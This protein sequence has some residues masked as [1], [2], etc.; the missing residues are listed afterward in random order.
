MAILQNGYNQNETVTIS[1][2]VNVLQRRYQRLMAAAMSLVMTA[3]P[4]TALAAGTK[5][6]GDLSDAVA[7]A[8]L[9]QESFLPEESLLT[10]DFENL[11]QSEDYEE[12]EEAFVPFT[13]PNAVELVFNGEEMELA[14]YARLVD[15]MTCVPVR[16]FFEA[17]E[18]EVNWD[19]AAGVIAI[20]R[21]DGL[22]MELIPGD[23]LARANGRCWYMARP[24]SVEEG[25]AMIPLRDAAKVFSCDVTWDPYCRAAYLEGGELL[26][27]GETYY[28]Q[29]DLLWI[30]RIVRHESCNQP[31]DG[32]V[33]VAN[34]II[35]RMND[36]G[37]PNTAEEVIYDTRNGVQ[38]VKRSSKSIL[39]DPC[40]T[41]WLAAKLAL[42][43]YE[44]APDCFFFASNKVA[45]TCWAGR[46]REVYT[47]IAGHTFFL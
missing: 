33:A 38:F 37:F 42:E 16:D 36:A 19:S 5:S 1:K 43:G 40:E 17:M 21:E 25:K 7:E 6:A 12:R 13:D 35:N 18:C 9:S 22:E 41:C 39:K 34:V 4:V 8:I 32:K 23:R 44:T 10:D 30:A 26:E 3:A 29:E 31:L 2:D 11:L 14:N 27:S 20:T 45:P 47:V 24:C 28:D 46:N 15:G